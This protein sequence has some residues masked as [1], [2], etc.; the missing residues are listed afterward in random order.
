MAMA[1]ATLP[2]VGRESAT[3][4][5]ESV[6]PVLV[7]WSN[8]CYTVKEKKQSREYVDKAVL[9][10]VAGHAAPGSFTV[11]LGASGS[12]KTSLL[13][14]LA[15]RLLYSKGA[16]LTGQLR[17]NGESAP[18]DYRMRCAY[19]QQTE[20]FYPFSTVRETVTMAARL[21]LGKSKAKD[22][23]VARAENVIQQLGLTKAID[24]VVG[25]GNRVKGISGG[26][27]KRVSIAC[28]LV[29]SPSVIML[30][31]PTSGLDSSAALKVVR[32]LTELADR[33]HTVVASIHQPG[34]AIYELFGTLV[35]LAEGELAYFGPAKN[36][37]K[38][39]SDVGYVCPPMFNP[40]EYVLDVT[41]IDSSSAASEEESRNRLDKIKMSGKET[42]TLARQVSTGLGPSIELTTSYL[43]QFV[44]LYRRIFRDA[45]RNKVALI[46]KFAQCI[47]TTLITV[48]LYSDLDGGV[49]MIILTKNIEALLFFV[50]I[51]GLFGPLFSTI[52]A[53]APEVNIVLRE[54]MNNLYAMAPYFMGKLAVA[55]PVELMPL[56]V[57]NSVAF[58]LLKLDHNVGRYFEYLL[59]TGGM[60]FS[61]VGLGF[62]LA[63][64]TGGNIQAASA[65]VGPIALI[66]LLLG[67][68]FINQSTIPAAISWFSKVSYVTWSYQGLCISQFNRRTI[69]V[70]GVELTP[71]GTCPS[72]STRM[73]CESGVDILS[74]NWNNGKHLSEHEWEATMWLYLVFIL[75]CICV[76]NFL[77]YL[78]LV[79]KGPKYLRL[80]QQ[81]A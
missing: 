22:A 12:G 10:D 26:E 23:K 75:I 16:T 28:E 5:G 25:D 78:V 4:Q 58:W 42:V 69:S 2:L 56:L 46:I 41:S 62:M 73:T 17:T 20:I 8:I 21:R 39:F 79:V 38:Y 70:K 55:L 72:D 77:A 53:F 64:A 6:H 11:I 9:K 29:S 51:N 3:A 65:A 66:F 33:G 27:M 50:T 35:V 34:S 47:T 48:A 71:D 76:F 60:T 59:F 30:D 44:L 37:V 31:E 24:T 43:E 36:V 18:Q 13:S 68:F 19:V 81:S 67:G 49:N 32:V 40:A 45:V 1:N 57:G 63:A 54:R 80:N 61:S 14:V 7:E 74:D 15:D 52:Q